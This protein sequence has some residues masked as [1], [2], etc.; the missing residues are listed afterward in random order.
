MEGGGEHGER[1][2]MR[3]DIARG[4]LSVGPV[5]CG[6]Q[7]LHPS[8]QEPREQRHHRLVGEKLDGCRASFKALSLWE[9]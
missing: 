5:P 4:R 6:S 1:E 7:A 3:R 9:K 2:S 8:S